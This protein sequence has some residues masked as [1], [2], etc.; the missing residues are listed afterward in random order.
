VWAAFHGLVELVYVASTRILWSSLDLRY[1]GEDLLYAAGLTMLSLG[2]LHFTIALFRCNFQTWFRRLHVPV[3]KP[4]AMF[5]SKMYL[6][7]H[8]SFIGMSTGLPAWCTTS[9]QGLLVL[10][11]QS[12]PKCV[13]VCMR[14]HARAGGN[15]P[16]ARRDRALVAICLLPHASRHRAWGTDQH[17]AMCATG[18]LR[19]ESSRSRGMEELIQRGALAP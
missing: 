16:A 17:R 2:L 1:D 12:H 5:Y 15:D 6:M 19:E 9:G 3:V 10:Q 14:A 7:N 8:V 18:W 4:V 11:A 13:C